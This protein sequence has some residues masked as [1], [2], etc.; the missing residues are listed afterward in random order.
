M[1]QEQCKCYIVLNDADDKVFTAAAGL[2]FR[3]IKYCCMHAQAPALQA[4]NIRLLEALEDLVSRASKS[5]HGVSRAQ[6]A[7]D[8]ARKDTP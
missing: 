3:E 1:V 5:G 7:I 8:K 6:T 4:E 2:K